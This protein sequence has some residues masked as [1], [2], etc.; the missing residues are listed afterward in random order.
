[1]FS[2]GAYEIKL[3]CINETKGEV[4]A[5]LA[6]H[7]VHFDISS[8]CAVNINFHLGQS[9][10]WPYNKLSEQSAMRKTLYLSQKLRLRMHEDLPRPTLLMEMAVEA[11]QRFRSPCCLHHQGDMKF[12][13]SETL[14][15]F[16]E[17]TRRNNPEDSHLQTHR[18]DNH[19]SYKPTHLL[20]HIHLITEVKLCVVFN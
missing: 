14:V 5:P 7:R 2:G 15:K 1:M 16:Y 3:I 8:Q 11:Y 18:Q 19:N 17:T 12:R 13:A 10:P 20:W 4:C 9:R 6:C